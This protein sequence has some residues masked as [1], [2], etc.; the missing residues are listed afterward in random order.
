M[1]L[2]R[3]FAVIL[4]ALTLWSCKKDVVFVPNSEN[5]LPGLWEQ[6]NDFE[7]VG[8]VRS[9]G[10]TIGSKGYVIGGNAA[11]GFNSELINDFWEYNPANDK[12]KRRADYPG[13]AGEYLKG[14]S[15]NG[16]GYVG[17]GFGRRLA[18]PGDDKPQNND[19][20]EYNPATNKWTRKADFAGGEREN[21]I[22]F[23]IDGKGYMG[24]GTDNDYNASFKDM[25]SYD[26]VADKWTRVA[27]YPGSGSFGVAAFACNGKG[28]AGTGGAYPNIAA[29]DFWQYDPVG[30]KWTK[31]ADFPGKG[32]AFSGQFVIGEK[33]YV[34]FGSTLTET[35]GDWYMYDTGKNSWQ[36]ITNFTGPI[37]Y[38]MVSFAINGVG[39]IGTGNPGLLTDFWKYTPRKT[40]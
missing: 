20:W 35:A 3:T 24:L 34:G 27:D 8:R 33:G 6:L 13:Q 2:K 1:I 23:E 11:S 18:I 40:D 9:F 10:F 19:F 16:K 17:T 22:A 39:Y 14:F 37:R 38:D 12:W 15:I 32:R 21:V 25:W 30:D 26:A 5:G 31:M 7:G 29:K 28:Y 36:K 4:I